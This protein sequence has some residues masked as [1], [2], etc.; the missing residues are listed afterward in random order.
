MAR[1]DEYRESFEDLFVKARKLKPDVVV[2]CGDIIDE[3][4]QR[5]SPE[6]ID[7]LNW[8]FTELA[9]IAPVHVI[10]GNHDGNLANLSRQD[11]IS[12]ILSL[13]DHQNI[14]FY[15]QSGTYPQDHDG[16]DVS[17]CVFSCFDEDGWEH[18][19]PDPDHI[20][21]ALFH[22]SV[23]GAKTDL[24]YALG[25]EVPIEFFDEFDFVLLGD[26]HLRQFLNE[27]KTI[28]Y[29]GSCIQQNFGEITD[30]GFLF[31]D[32][33][34]KDDFDVKFH[35]I[36]QP[37]P[38]ITIEWQ[39][40][41]KKT[42][43]LASVDNARYRVTS[44]DE[45]SHVDKSHLRSEIGS[46]VVYEPR[47]EAVSQAIPK[48]FKVSK[49]NL[50]DPQELLGL[51]QGLYPDTFSDDEWDKIESLVKDTLKEVTKDTVVRNTEWGLR[52]LGFDNTFS[53]N[54][55]NL[56]DFD[57]AQGITGIFAP[58]RSG[59]SSIIGTIM[60]TLFN[61]TD[62]GPTKNQYVVN[63]R[64]ESCCTD[65]TFNVSGVDYKIERETTNTRGRKGQIKSSTSLEFSQVGTT[66][67]TDVKRQETEKEIRKVIGSPEDFLLTAVAAAGD[68]NAFIE[69]KNTARKA[70]FSRFLELD[71]CEQLHDIFKESS[72]DI[73]KTFKSMAEKDWDVVVEEL[74]EERKEEGV[75]VESLG[76]K[77]KALRKR[78]EKQK[79]E[80]ESVSGSDEIVTPVDVAE[81]E[82]EIED[83]KEDI[84]DWESGLSG[85][86]DELKENKTA[87]TRINKVKKTFP[88]EDY[89]HSLSVVRK[90]NS[91][92]SEIRSDLRDAKTVLGQKEKSVK[93]LDFV[94]CDD[95]YP[96]CKFI[97]DSHEDKRM[98]SEYEERVKQLIAKAE[99]KEESINN[100]DEEE[101]EAKIDKYEKLLKKGMSL[102]TFMAKL[103]TKS[104]Q[105]ESQIDTAKSDLKRCEKKLIE[106][107]DQVVEP[108][109]DKSSVIVSRIKEMLEEEKRF[110]RERMESASRIGQVEA[111]IKQQKKEKDSYQKLRA[112]WRIYEKLIYAFSKR[113][114]PSQII[115]TRL[116]EVNAEIAKIISGV[117][118]FKIDIEVNEDSNELEI[119]M[120]EDGDRYPVEL[121]SGM[122]K[123]VASIAIRVAL[124]NISS[125]PK[126]DMLFI[127][128]AFDTFDDRNVDLC[129]RMFVALKRWFKNV[130]IISHNEQVKT[131]AD[132]LIEIEKVGKD[133]HVWYG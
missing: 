69:K 70:V 34:S 60:Y 55:G 21:I 68:M 107:K 122:E 104:V 47:R 84:E 32:I 45:L 125:L 74:Q 18:V 53:Y 130:V 24:D 44:D 14:S 79:R 123:K 19:E 119:L 29:P 35:R 7:Q 1:H 26:V 12:P 101:I 110:D 11:A 43:A 83:T 88:I 17:F 62:R 120:N 93:K 72:K 25:A 106:L 42:L 127:D 102:E 118:P 78:I 82:K 20:N 2:V 114:I 10:L 9:K 51:L 48:G 4:T 38:F 92:L 28:A 91:V 87:I 112:Q 111:E 33:R 100:L 133:S 52:R 16:W 6:L 89:R 56:I 49:L 131:I 129:A 108:S 75:N 117:A 132:N 23:T 30:K 67:K 5:I 77:L 15:K 3:K 40:S 115:R 41:V 105:L 97:K 63:V 96:T 86:E 73:S 80:L 113:G 99:K 85:I 57:K 81:Q 64:K 27:E 71:V 36:K 54:D 109:D 121:S 22:G 116:P 90:V 124:M 46:E 94:P 37:K 95:E 126:P 61:T 8:W 58:N 39:G 13:L 128:E 76:K 103:K 31:W 65:L 50:R 59:K 98:L 66:P